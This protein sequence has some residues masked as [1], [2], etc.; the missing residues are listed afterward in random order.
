M[1]VESG[2]KDVTLV[3][4]LSLDDEL[5]SKGLARDIIRRVQA[6][7]KELNLR[8]EASISLELSLSQDSPEL[9][10]DDWNH[11]LSETRSISGRRSDNQSPMESSFEL[12]G[13][14]VGFTVTPSED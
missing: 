10:E 3:L 11:I 6:K 12:D 14:V 13:S 7:R 4:D 1:T 2:G 8:I 5:L 9:A